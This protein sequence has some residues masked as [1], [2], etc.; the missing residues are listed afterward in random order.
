M[1]SMLWNVTAGSALLA[2]AS[3]RGFVGDF[4][5]TFFF[6][7]RHR[8]LFDEN[9]VRPNPIPIF[10]LFAPQLFDRGIFDQSLYSCLISRRNFDRKRTALPIAHFRFHDFFHRAHLRRYQY[11]S[12]ATS[13]VLPTRTH[14]PS[15][16][17]SLSL[18]RGVFSI[19]ALT[20]RSSAGFCF[21]RSQ[22][23]SRA[24][25]TRLLPE[26]RHTVACVVER[27]SRPRGVVE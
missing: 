21:E 14:R 9:H 20:E 19:R 23:R 5:C 26:I 16:S 25:H 11:K 12:R 7:E 24:R 15:L 8:S 1:Q 22:S 27:V 18:T 2:H 4:V 10:C 13:T 3:L 17:A 6:A